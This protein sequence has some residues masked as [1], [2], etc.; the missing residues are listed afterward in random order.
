MVCINNT[1]YV[2]TTMNNNATTCD[3]KILY[4]N[5]CSVFARGMR[6]T[7]PRVRTESQENTR[8]E[9]NNNIYTINVK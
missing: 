2:S 5:V 4:Y 7:S 6:F 3:W 1:M 9:N 8:Q